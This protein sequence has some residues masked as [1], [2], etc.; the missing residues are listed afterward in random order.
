MPKLRRLWTPLLILVA[1]VPSLTG[2]IL[3]YNFYKVYPFFT[4]GV[5][6]EQMN[7][8]MPTNKIIAYM[9]PLLMFL[10][11]VFALTTIPVYLVLLRRRECEL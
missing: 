4:Y 11:I 7:Y 10:L 2:A 1:L 3:M 6:L 5:T 8:G 9:T